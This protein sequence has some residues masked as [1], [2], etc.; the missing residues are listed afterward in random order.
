MIFKLVLLIML[1]SA[2]VMTAPVEQQRTQTQCVTEGRARKFAEN[3][4]L[5]EYPK[6]MEPDSSAGLVF[7]AVEFG[8]DG[9][10]NKMKVYQTPGPQATEAVRNV[11]EKWKLRELFDGGGQPIKTRTGLKFHFVFDDGKGRVDVANEQEQLEFG[12]EWGKKVCRAS[13]DD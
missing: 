8:T 3:S 9:K 10:F 2:V 11:I 6:E 1:G 12:G 7:V 13:L 4:P 5:P